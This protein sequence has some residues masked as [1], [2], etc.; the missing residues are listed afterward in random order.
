[1]STIYTTSGDDLTSIANAIRTKGGTSASLS[2]PTE[3]VDAINAIPSSGGLPVVTGSF[4]TGELNA[5]E[6]INI[7]YSGS[8]Y[9]IRMRIERDGGYSSGTYYQYNAVMVLCEKAHPEMAPTFSSGDANTAIATIISKSSSSSTNYNA[10]YGVRYK[11]GD[12]N[13]GSTYTGTFSI[14]SETSIKIRVA[15]GTGSSNRGFIPETK[16][17]YWITYSE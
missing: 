4:T 13:N 5:V 1:M 10:N 3:F 8:G 2:Y 7:P 16:Y 6:T 15:N 12:P 11:T 9:P 14:P 17:N